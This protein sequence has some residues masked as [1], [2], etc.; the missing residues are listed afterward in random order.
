MQSETSSSKQRR[1]DP[2]FNACLLRKNL[3]RFW[4]I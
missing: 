4:P 2:W 1:P 3:T